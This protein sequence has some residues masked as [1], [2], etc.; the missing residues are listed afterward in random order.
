MADA[1]GALR[2]GV[3]WSP[4]PRQVREWSVRLPA[5]ACARDALEASGLY[6]EFPELRG[7]ALDL[8][9]W[10]RLAAP[11]QALREGDRV[12]VLRPLLVDPKVA[13]RER[14]QR[15]GARTAGLFSKR[16]GRR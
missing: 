13:R 12:E 6:D 7:R 2:V 8:S 9:V 10:G 4:A 1:D 3:A 14:F 16:P 15:Q 5:G 11:G